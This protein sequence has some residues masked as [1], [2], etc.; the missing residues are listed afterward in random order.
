MADFFDDADDFR[1]KLKN[2]VN[3]FNK[4]TSLIIIKF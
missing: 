4:R 3:N 2:K 1:K